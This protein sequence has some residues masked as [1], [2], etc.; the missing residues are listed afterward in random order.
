[1]N[2]GRQGCDEGRAADLVVVA[3]PEKRTIMVRQTFWV[4][5]LALPLH[6]A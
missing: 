6:G 2:D 1:M 4:L 3:H 5:P